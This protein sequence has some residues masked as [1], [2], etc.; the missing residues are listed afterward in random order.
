MI[1]TGSIYGLN[2][3]ADKHEKPTAAHM[4][5]AHLDDGHCSHASA[6]LQEQKPSG[7]IDIDTPPHC[8]L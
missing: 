5:A 1:A 7:S 8:V 4:V 2:G 6:T 3:M